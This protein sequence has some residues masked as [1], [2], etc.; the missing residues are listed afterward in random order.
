MPQPMGSSA[1]RLA[2]LLS[3]VARF[4]A[5]TLVEA[6]RPVQSCLRLAM[7]AMCL[8]EHCRQLLAVIAFN[9]P[10]GGQHV[11]DAAVVLDGSVRLWVN[12]EPRGAC[13]LPTVM[14]RS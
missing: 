9:S 1:I 6:P 7:T 14:V 2:T 11:D 10:V 5:S 8:A 12:G 4:A 13:H 3:H